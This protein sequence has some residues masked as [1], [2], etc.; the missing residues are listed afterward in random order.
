MAEPTGTI[1]PI[2]YSPSAPLMDRLYNYINQPQNTED[3]L[4][5]LV[6]GA[7]DFIP[8]ISTELA[9]RRGDKFGEALS[10][11]DVL[12]GGKPAVMAGTFLVARAKLVRKIQRQDEI[13]SRSTDP[14]ENAAAQKERSSYVKDLKKMDV[15][16]ANKTR[17]ITKASAQTKTGRKSDF[18]PSEKTLEKLSSKNF[19]Q[20]E[21]A[22][23]RT[24][25]PSPKPF[26]INELATQIRRNEDAG[27]PLLFRGE[28]RESLDLSKPMYLTK[29]A[30]DSRLPDFSKKGLYALQSKFKNILDVDNIPP[31]VNQAITDREMFRGRPSRSGGANQTDFDIERMLGGI[32]D[33]ANK[34]PSSINKETTDFFEKQGYDALRFPPRKFKGESDTLLSLDPVNNLKVFDEVPPDM[35]ED[36]MRELLRNKFQ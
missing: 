19:D 32:R 17:D 22:L 7:A 30:L 21:L 3:P 8:G 25:T 1:A 35:V 9:R 26:D 12:A 5:N 13:L 31:K 33:S 18:P 10:Y 34:T 36:L 16:E 27:T 23:T 28:R 15:E 29:N 6:S 4:Q 2:P 24:R 20:G 11:L 14:I